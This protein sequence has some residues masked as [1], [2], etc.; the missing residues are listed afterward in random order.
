ML[1]K[2]F[3]TLRVL[4]DGPEFP[5]DT[6]LIPTDLFNDRTAFTDAVIELFEK[7]D[8]RDPEQLANFYNFARFC[9]C[10]DT[11][12]RHRLDDNSGGYIDGALIQ[13]SDYVETL[14]TIDRVFGVTDESFGINVAGGAQNPNPVFS[15]LSGGFLLLCKDLLDEGQLEVMKIWMKVQ[16]DA[17]KCNPSATGIW[18]LD[19]LREIYS[20]ESS[21][22][23][24]DDVWLDP[25]GENDNRYLIQKW[26]LH[27]INAISQIW[28]AFDEA[29]QNL[30]EYSFAAQLVQY[31]VALQA[32]FAEEFEDKFE[33]G[34]V[35]DVVPIFAGTGVP[36]NI[37]QCL[38]VLLAPA[39]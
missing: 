38:L 18:W 14:N 28:T 22:D 10:I 39:D 17:C 6:S 29:A 9:V 26:Y 27:L 36:H 4:V 37:E 3:N 12:I 34:L 19:T 15:G 31:T 23:S 32:E 8:T 24:E 35:C 5:E 33:N 21:I 7:T 16:L 1:E 11:S 2:M 30:P 20:Y 25:T 13:P